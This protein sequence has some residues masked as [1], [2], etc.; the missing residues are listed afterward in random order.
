MP[1]GAEALPRQCT[2]RLGVVNGHTGQRCFDLA[3]SLPCTQL[4][5]S[6]SLLVNSSTS[7]AR[8][9]GQIASPPRSGMWGTTNA[10]TFKSTM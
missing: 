9:C 6:R 2:V 7:M 5:F 10:S 3:W 1:E 8:Y 4:H